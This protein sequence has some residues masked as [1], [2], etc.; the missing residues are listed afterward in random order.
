MSWKGRV[1]REAVWVICAVAG[2]LLA[3]RIFDFMR[4]ETMVWSWND[5]AYFRSRPYKDPPI[6]A[7]VSI[8][9]V[10]FVRLS[11]WAIKGIKRRWRG[12]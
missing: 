9:V 11:V 2:G 5:L 6:T 12:V 8:G 1:T 3:S 7:M 10:Y 4:P